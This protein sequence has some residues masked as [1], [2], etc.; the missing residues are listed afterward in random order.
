MEKNCVKF[1][2]GGIMSFLSS[3]ISP[4][5]SLASN[6][7]SLL[8][9]TPSQQN[10]GYSALPNQLQTSFNQL[11]QDVSQYTNPNDP[12]N[13]ARFTPI[14]QTGSETQ[15]YNTINQGITPTANSLNSDLSMLMNPFN[16]SVIGGINNAANSADSI[17]KQNMTQ[18]GQFGSNRQQ[19]GANDIE[20]QRQN[21]IGSLLQNQ[22]NQALGQVFNNLVPERQQDIT[23]QLGEGA[24]QRQL[25]YQTA[26]AP[27]SSL[28]AGTSMIAP[29]TAGGTATGAT[30][31]PLAAIGQLASGAGTA[32]M[33]MSDINLK[34][35]I[36]YIGKENG[37]KIY[38]FK[39]KGKDGHY[40]GVMAQEVL[41]INPEAVVTIN[42][43]LAVNYDKIGIEFRRVS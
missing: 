28:Q 11:G 29:F 30:P 42:G 33:A 37:Y 43:H 27:I 15:A 9:G 3:L 13:V 19:L 10:S 23:N 20:L 35:D 2:V 39:Y 25:A 26:Q 16:N 17:L 34:E 32:A 22:Y 31:S 21:Q 7:G 12:A 14:P 18:A 5:T 38:D 36:N 6:G 41:E 40:R 4:L 1:M 24:Q 8:T